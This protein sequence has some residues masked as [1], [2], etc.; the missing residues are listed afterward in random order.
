L[1]YQNQFKKLV[2]FFITILVLNFDYISAWLACGILYN[3]CILIFVHDTV[4]RRNAAVLL[5]I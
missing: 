3:T 2:L 5:V 4:R 1:A